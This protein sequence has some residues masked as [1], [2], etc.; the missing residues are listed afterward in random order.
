MVVCQ[1]TVAAEAYE[2]PAVFATTQNRISARKSVHVL[3][4]IAKHVMYLCQRFL[5]A[6]PKCKVIIL[7]VYA[8]LSPHQDERVKPL[9]FRVSVNHEVRRRCWASAGERWL[10]GTEQLKTS[11]SEIS[12]RK[13]AT[14][15]ARRYGGYRRRGTSGNPLY[16]AVHVR[17]HQ[18]NEG[19]VAPTSFSAIG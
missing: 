2:H 11:A 1:V 19:G 13:I 7:F 9:N 10:S 3:C 16:S 5:F 18:D 6:Y 14:Q 15:H 12:R 17:A 4:L 8:V